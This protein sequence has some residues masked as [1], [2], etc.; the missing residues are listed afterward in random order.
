M[1]INKKWSQSETELLKIFLTKGL[2]LQEIADYLQRSRNSVA[3]LSSDIGSGVFARSHPDT[4]DK[5]YLLLQNLEAVNGIID[6][7]INSRTRK[8]TG[9]K[10]KHVGTAEEK[11]VASSHKNTLTSSE[12]GSEMSTICILPDKTPEASARYFG[13]SDEWEPAAIQ[14]NIWEM[15]YVD[16]SDPKNVKPGSYPLYQI[17]IRWVRKI[18]SKSQFE[19]FV[20]AIKKIAPT[21][22]RKFK[23]PTK[24]DEKLLIIDLA[25]IH[26][27]KLAL[28]EES[29]RDYNIAIAEERVMQGVTKLLEDTAHNKIDLIY[30]VAGN[31]ALHTDDPMAHATTRGTPQDTQTRWW[32]AFRK[33][34]TL[35]INVINK[36]AKV[37]PVNYIFCSSNHDYLTGF[38]LAE[39]LEAYFSK[40][41]R[42]IFDISPGVRTYKEYGKNLLCFEHGD[43]IKRIEKAHDLMASNVPEMWGRTKYRYIYLHHIHHKERAVY[44]TKDAIGVT[45]ESLRTPCTADAWHAAHGYTNM[46]AL[47]CFMHDKNNGQT[48][49]HSV[50]F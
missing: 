24:K 9:S 19:D 12:D 7:I 25:D 22:T 14:T 5:Y 39:C 28:A 21:S 45:F 32:D 30:L 17:K 38:F 49:R 48:S 44:M 46:P 47:E 29:G 50:Y 3:R 41:E 23:R 34:K 36:L 43:K 42:V 11:G 33:A 27:N 10:S 2:T 18:L 40:N 15:G 1:K 26:I 16:N 4:Q 35:Y 37:A 31:D 6:S 8:V 20:K 13:I